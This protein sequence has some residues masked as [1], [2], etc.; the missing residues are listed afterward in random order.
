MWPAL[1]M[2]AGLPVPQRVVAHGF[3]TKDGLKMGKS[4]GNVLDPKALVAAYGADAVRFFFMKEITF[5]EVAPNPLPTPISVQRELR[6]TALMVR[7][8][9]ICQGI[10]GLVKMSTFYQVCTCRCDLGHTSRRIHCVPIRHHCQHFN[11]LGWQ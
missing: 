4:L 3:L 6:Q 5:G 9:G 7:R 10:E 8:S 11:G 1:L 2:S